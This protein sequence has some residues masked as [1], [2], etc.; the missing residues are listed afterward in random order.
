MKKGVFLRNWPC[1]IWFLFYF[2][3]F[4][5][6]CGANIISLLAV[7][8]VY[9]IGILFSLSPLAESLWRATSGI[10]PLRTK[11]EK[12]RL[13]PLFKEVYLEAYKADKKIS[14][15]IKPY[16][17]ESMDINAFAFGRNTLVI[18][19]G[20]IELLNDECLKGLLAHEFGHFSGLDPAVLLVMN[21]GNLFMFLLRKII[22]NKTDE[23]RFKENKSI[24][25]FILKIVYDLFYGIYRIFKFLGDVI[26]TS[27]SREHEYEADAFAHSCGY[28]TE[29]TNLLYAIY[30]MTISRP[31]SIKEQLRSSHPPITKR[32]QAL[33]KIPV[34][35]NMAETK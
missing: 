2:A 17:Q 8:L 15:N 12:R 3:L 24:L 11:R 32:I 30:G 33:E 18:T 35:K 7:A 26:I 21:V 4:W 13:I 27:I 23:P 16:I 5:L 22:C 29:I 20:S 34:V 25:G 19:R 1:V 31:G 14:R 10:R 28:G 6:L 9:S